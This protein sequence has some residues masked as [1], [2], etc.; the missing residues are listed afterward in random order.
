MNLFSTVVIYFLT[1]TFL[2][3]QK[4]LNMSPDW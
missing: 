2:N 3:I 4:E 1:F